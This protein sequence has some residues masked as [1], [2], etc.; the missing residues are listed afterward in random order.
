LQA[1]GIEADEVE[2][3][4]KAAGGRPDEAREFLATGRDPA[5]WAALPMALAQG[6]VAVVKDWSA[7]QLIDALQKLCH[8]L[9]VAR[10]GAKPRFFDL[11]SL[12]KHPTLDALSAWSTSLRQ[13]TKTMEHP[14]NP[15]LMTEALVGQAQSTLNSR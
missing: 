13:A 7:P 8:D 15:G 6:Q 12:P 10:V 4:L 14:F 3:M 1:Q 5:Q 2:P 11:N 9:M